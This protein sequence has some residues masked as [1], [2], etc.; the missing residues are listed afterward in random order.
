[1]AQEQDFLPDFGPDLTHP[2]VFLRGA[3][4]LYGVEAIRDWL[5]QAAAEAAPDVDAA[6]SLD[7]LPTERDR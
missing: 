2:L 6:E 4:R 3:V 7:L 5:E 1:M